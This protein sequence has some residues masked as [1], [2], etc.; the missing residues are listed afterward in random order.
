MCLLDEQNNTHFNNEKG[1][2][3]S[4]KI[5]MESNYNLDLYLLIILC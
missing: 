5:H 2:H 1:I 3:L 4:S